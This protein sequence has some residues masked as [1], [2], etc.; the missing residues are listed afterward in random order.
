MPTEFD[1]DTGAEVSVI[2]E[3]Q[4]KVIGSPSLSPAS[5]RLRG[6]SNYSLPVTGCFTGILKRGSQEVHQEIFVVKNL[7][8][9]LLGRPAIDALGLAVRVGAIF[10]GDTSPVQMFPQMF[11]GLGKLEGSMRLNSDQTPSRLQ[12]QSQDELLFL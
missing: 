7:R 2:S 8:C 10:D 6:P 4:H 12:S 11:Q 3:K 1:I 5:R 9:Q